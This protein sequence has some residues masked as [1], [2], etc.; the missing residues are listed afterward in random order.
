MHSTLDTYKTK[1]QVTRNTLKKPPQ[2]EQL[3]QQE[4]EP[5]SSAALLF[6]ALKVVFRWKSLIIVGN[7]LLRKAG[8]SPRNR[9]PLDRFQTRLYE[10]LESFFGY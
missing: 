4:Y 7:Y 2:K 6:K 5:E 8:W 9:N 3:P 1:K 10:K